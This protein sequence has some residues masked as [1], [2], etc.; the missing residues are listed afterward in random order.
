MATSLT[1]FLDVDSAKVLPFGQHECCRAGKRRRSGSTERSMRFNSFQEQLRHV[2]SI[3]PLT[4]LYKPLLRYFDEPRSRQHSCW[5]N[6]KLHVESALDT[7]LPSNFFVL[8]FDNQQRFP[9]LCYCGAPS[10]T[11][12]PPPSLELISLRIPWVSW[13]KRAC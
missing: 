3:L 7:V 1:S 4:C 5:P 6:G 8:I 2:K 9:S 13:S 11:F 12:L 10:V